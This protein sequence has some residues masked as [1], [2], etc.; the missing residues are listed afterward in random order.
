[1]PTRSPAVAGL[2]YPADPRRL[3]ALVG[4]MLAETPPPPAE[5]SARIE[6]LIVPHAGLVYSGP[7]AASAYA[8]LASLGDRIERV[9]LLGPAHRVPVRGLAAPAVDGFETPFGVVPVDRAAIDALADLPQVSVDD[10]PH[11]LEHS[12]EVQLPFL[13]RLLGSFSL[14]PFVVGEASGTEVAAVIERLR[15]AGTLVVV[16]SDLSHYHDYETARA[17]DAATCAAIERLD[18]AA[19]EHDSACGRIPVRGLLEVARSHGLVP[20][21]LDLRSSGDTAGDR[22]RVVGYGAWAFSAPERQGPPAGGGPGQGRDDAGAPASGAPAAKGGDVRDGAAAEPAAAERAAHDALLLELAR[23]SIAEGL[24]SGRPLAAAV[25][26]FPD[27][28][29]APGACFVTLRDARGALRGCI[30]TLEP[31]RALCEDVVHNAF[32]AAFGDPRMRPVSHA[33]LAT[34]RI[35]I[36]LLGRREPL[37]VRSRADLLAC[38]RPGRDGLVL[39]DGGLRGTLLPQVWSQLPDPHVLVGSVFAKAGLPA[40]HWSPT[41]RAWRYGVRSVAEPPAA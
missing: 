1:M 18:G 37:R 32:A 2:F 12:L 36:S 17:L 25:E 5:E 39:E 8:A 27:L 30:G 34:L 21:T 20:R 29:R 16:S 26:S 15:G 7:V 38:L 24:G 41:V 19:L 23:R 14:V 35:E 33:E 40:D 6:A 9:V 3:E 28:L 10:G 31:H 13:Q 11:A 22:R 4:A